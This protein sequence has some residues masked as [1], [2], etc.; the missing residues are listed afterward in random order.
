MYIWIKVVFVCVYSG[1]SPASQRGLKQNGD[2]YFIINT[3]DLKQNTS[4]YTLTYYRDI[5]D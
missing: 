5:F 2:H 1:W 4:F 3:V